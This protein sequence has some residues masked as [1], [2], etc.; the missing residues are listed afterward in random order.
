MLCSL[1]GP[2]WRDVA[3]ALNAEEAGGG[4]TTDK[5]GARRGAG[6]VDSEDEEGWDEEGRV[7]DVLD[8]RLRENA[9]RNKKGAGRGQLQGGLR[10]E[11]CWLEYLVERTG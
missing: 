4:T 2:N 8:V 1:L 10:P 7:T 5:G 6:A 3:A 9:P 11:Q